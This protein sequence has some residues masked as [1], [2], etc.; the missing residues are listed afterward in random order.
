MWIWSFLLYSTF[1]VLQDPSS[2][3]IGA[4]QPQREQRRRQRPQGDHLTRKD[5]ASLF[6]AVRLNGDFSKWT[7]RKADR[8]TPTKTPTNSP[9]VSH[10]KMAVRKAETGTTISDLD[11]V[12]LADDPSDSDLALDLGYRVLSAVGNW[13]GDGKEVDRWVASESIWFILGK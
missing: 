1:L 12:F 5:A 4:P 13:E 3:H 11:L 9:V 2:P 8:C 7:E 10:R 6:E